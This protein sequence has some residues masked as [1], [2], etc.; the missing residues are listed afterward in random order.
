MDDWMRLGNE[1]RD[2]QDYETAIEYYKKAADA[3]IT[4]AWYELRE[5]YHGYGKKFKKVRDFAKAKEAEQKWYECLLADGDES[6]HLMLGGIYESN[7]DYLKAVGHYENAVKNANDNEEQN[8]AEES[9]GDIYYEGKGV[10]QDYSKALQWYEKAACHGNNKAMFRLGIMYHD[11]K[12]TEPNLEKALEWCQKASA[13]GM[14][15]VA[16]LLLNKWLSK[17]SVN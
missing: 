12:G 16:D 2:R 9:L 3:G 6:V 11:G 5:I 4:N 10:A 7:G 13:T 15:E 17:E 14:K 1:A 8:S